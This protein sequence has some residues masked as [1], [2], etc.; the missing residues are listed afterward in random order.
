MRPEMRPDRTAHAAVARRTAHTGGLLLSA[1]VLMA[2]A[3][4]RAQGW[5]DTNKGMLPPEG[6]PATPENGGP[7]NFR[8]TGAVL[9]MEKPSISGRVL[10][11]YPPGTIFDNLGCQRVSAQVWCDVQKLGGGPRGYVSAGVLKPA[12]SPDGSVAAGDD[13]S[14]LRAGR[15]DFDA[16]G[17]IPCAMTLG[18][19]SSSCSFGVARAGGGYA[20]VVVSKADGGRRAI[21]FRMG[22]AIG[23]DT[24]EADP[25]EFSVRREGDLHFIRVGDER[26]E[27]PDAVVLGG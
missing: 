11:T 9:L 23:A 16:T 12:V 15:G 1:L 10:G 26:Y 25:G 19:P 13:D 8:A 14:A 2:S 17:S 20:T 3:A 27:I 18:Q 5:G 7:R 24:S 4:V 21:Y 22:R 6:V